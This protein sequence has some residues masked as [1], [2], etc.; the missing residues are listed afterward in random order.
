MQSHGILITRVGV[1]AMV[2]MSLLVVSCG[3][4][5]GS[6]PNEG[7]DDSV[8]GNGPGSAGRLTV[9]VLV[10]DSLMLSDLGGGATPNLD[11]LVASGTIYEESRAMFSAETIPN[12]VAMMTGVT[13]RRNGIPTNNFWDRDAFPDTPGDEDL[14]KPKELSANTLFTWI[15]QRCGNLATGA[16]LSKKYLYEIFFGDEPGTPNDNPAV[17][18]VQP[19]NYWDPTTDPAYLP[20]PDEHTPDLNTMT[21]ALRQLPLSDFL[22]INLGD[23]DRSAHAAGAIFR[24]AVIADTDAQVGRMVQALRDAGRWKNTV[25]IMV[26]DHGMDFSNPGVDTITTQGALDQITACGYEPMLAVDNGGTDSIYVTNLA[27]SQSDRQRTLRAARACLLA[28]NGADCSAVETACGGVSIAPQ[29]NVLGLPPA[30]PIV[31]GWYIQADAADPAGTMPASVMSAHENLG[32][33]VLVA[34]DGLKF[35]ESSPTSNPI[36]GNH[37]HFVT[38]HN[39]MVVSGGSAFLKPGNRVAASSPSPGPL[40]RLPE[41]SEN[42]DVAPTVAWLLSMPIPAA[43]FPDFAAG[44]TQGFDG[45]VLSEAFLPFDSNPAAAPPSSCGLLIN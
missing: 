36:P 3:G 27:A 2:L 5:G 41:Q 32:D 11:A 6:L 45:R 10:I 30:E 22:F 35:A 4:S 23:V 7:A 20:D 24:A 39:T 26:S 29:V 33:L 31:A 12:H 19:D 14:S 37:G 8:P 43:D 1:M 38:L 15:D 9:V 16:A 18:N 28:P 13:P 42:M 17:A 44:E 40:D 25:L 21:E 34:N